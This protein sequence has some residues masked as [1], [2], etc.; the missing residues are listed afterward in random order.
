VKQSA[1]LK[2]TWEKAFN[3]TPKW[4]VVLA[5]SFSARMQQAVRNRDSNIILAF[6]FPFQKPENRKNLF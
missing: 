1:R 2:H 3:S 6:D 4:E 5:L